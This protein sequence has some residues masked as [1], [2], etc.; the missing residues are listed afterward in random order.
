[1]RDNAKQHGIADARGK[2]GM[3]DLQTEG[4]AAGTAQ[5]VLIAEAP[6]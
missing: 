5:R 1:V 4:S 2:I 3:M 6:E